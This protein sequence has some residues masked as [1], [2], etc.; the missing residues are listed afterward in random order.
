MD[1]I[2]NDSAL[3][4]EYGLRKTRELW[5]LTQELKKVRRYARLQLSRGEEGKAEGQSI[6]DKLS[7]LGIGKQD[8]KLEDVLSLTIRDFLDRRLQSHVVKKGLAHS[9]KQAR[10]LITHGFISVNG[11]KVTIPSYVVTAREEPTVSYYRA[12]D[13]S[14]PEKEEKRA[15]SPKMAAREAHAKEAADGAP[16][17]PTPGEGA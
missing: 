15:A 13:I 14:H 6:L 1:R 9:P 17:A 16:A 3:A 12:I 5:T 8:M 11:K 4:R 10:Q 2:R 7:R